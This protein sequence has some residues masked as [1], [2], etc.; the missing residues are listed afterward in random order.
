MVFL[1]HLTA[2]H[3]C[4]LSNVRVEPD[5]STALNLSLTLNQAYSMALQKDSDLERLKEQVRVLG[6]QVQ[7]ERRARLEADQHA[8]EER[9]ARLDADQ[10]AEEERRA[11]LDADQHA[12]EER[13]VRLDADRARFEEKRLARHQTEQ[14]IRKSTFHEYLKGCHDYISRRLSTQGSKSLATTGALT[15][16]GGK[17]CPPNS[18]SGKNSKQHKI[19]V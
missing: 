16:V 11:R 17:I 14:Y 4:Y 13:R 5:N 2:S 19:L 6:R 9:Q 8:A 3:S 10:P 7:E 1:R 15:N 12:E 18:D